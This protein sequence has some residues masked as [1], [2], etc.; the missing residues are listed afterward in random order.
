MK[1]VIITL[2][3]PTCSGKSTLAGIM[4]KMFGFAEIVSTTTRPMRDG[5]ID[6][7]HYH[8]VTDE[9]FHVA[10]M[11]GEFVESVEFNGRY[12]YAAS[13][14]EFEK[15]FAT[16]KP[17]VVV[18]EPDGAAQIREYSSR[19]GWHHTAVYVD[20]PLEVL[21]ARFLDR[22]GN[23]RN[24]SV[25]NYAGRLKELVTTGIHWCDIM[26]YDVVINGYDDFNRI[27][28]AE[29]LMEIG[30]LREEAVA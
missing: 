20:N 7:V 3:G 17:V 30:A 27:S 4:A 19:V 8:F 23:D 18:V 6:G 21:L 9:D 22:F 2:T 25:G 14:A 11:A 29:G 16:G 13:R 28:V 10:A 15:A 1:N 26:N 12:H 5:E 24:G